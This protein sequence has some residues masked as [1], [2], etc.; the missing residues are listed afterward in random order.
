MRSE[1]RGPRPYGPGEEVSEDEYVLG[2]YRVPVKA[3]TGRKAG[4]APESG[5]LEAYADG[6]AL[7]AALRR[8]GRS[9]P[10]LARHEP[11]LDF[12]TRIGR[13]A[14]AGLVRELEQVDLTRSPAGE[15]EVLRLLLDWGRQSLAE[16]GALRI[17]IDAVQ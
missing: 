6:G 15:R 7:R 1:T 13:P 14:M 17:E 5:L 10:T 9:L 4:P 12:S 2:L 11:D 16:G 8:L 3:R